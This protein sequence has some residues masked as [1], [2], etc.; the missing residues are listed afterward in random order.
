M[1]ETL[2]SLRED[3]Y[4]IIPYAGPNLALYQIEQRLAELLELRNIAE[5]DGD[6]QAVEA[7]DKQFEAYFHAEV[8]KVDGICHALHSFEQAANA[9][10]AEANRLFKRCADLESHYD[11]IRAATLKAMQDHGVR[12]LETPTN[13]LRVQ[14]NG[15]KMPLE[16]VDTGGIPD[17]LW[18][19]TLHL[20]GIEIN[21]L[22]TYLGNPVPAGEDGKILDAIF[23]RIEEL[24]GEPDN[25]AIRAALKQQVPCSECEGKGKRIA[26]FKDGQADTYAE[27]SRCEGRG[28]IPN[29]IPGAK[30]L[31]RGFHL[32]IE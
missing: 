5:E 16:I 1:K 30:L 15:G 31:S 22:S 9:A 25:E 2:P 20:S 10:R 29:T 18:K 12:V 23:E 21:A 17:R 4:G 26:T 7:I 6:A 27:C 28:T 3:Q 11:R 8:R 13:K 14:A 24:Q 19:Y 32:R